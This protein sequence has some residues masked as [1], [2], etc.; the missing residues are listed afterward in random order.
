[1]HGLGGVIMLEVLG[2]IP[3]AGAW[4][5][6]RG[7]SALVAAAALFFV[8]ITLPVGSA[9]GGPLAIPA[10]PILIAMVV[11]MTGEAFGPADGSAGMG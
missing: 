1:V 8:V 6:W 9:F 4:F 2:L 5:A 3:A 10:R 7:R 11:S